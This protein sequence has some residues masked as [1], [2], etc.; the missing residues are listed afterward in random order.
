MIKPILDQEFIPAIVYNRK[1]LETANRP[2]Q[3][4]VER[5]NG[6]IYRYDTKIGD[7]KEVNFFYVERLIKMLL[8]SV[9]GFKIYL[10]GDKEVYEYIICTIC[11][12]T[13]DY[14]AGKPECG[15]IFPAFTDRSADINHVNIYQ[16]D[17]ERPHLELVKLLGV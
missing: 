1:F 7:D 13:G 9:G 15:F 14:E 5:E 3:I 8:W 6:L 11:P 2:L 17:V 16:A 4:A 12:V 10:N